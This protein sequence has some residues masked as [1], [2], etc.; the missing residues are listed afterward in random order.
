MS[1]LLS[2]CTWFSISDFHNRT[3]RC[4]NDFRYGALGDWEHTYGT[5]TPSFWNW[6]FLTKSTQPNCSDTT[7]SLPMSNTNLDQ[8]PKRG[9]MPPMTNYMAR[10][11]WQYPIS[12]DGYWISELD[13]EISHH[14]ATAIQLQNLIRLRS[15]TQRNDFQGE[16]HMKHI[17]PIIPTK[18]EKN[19]NPKLS[20]SSWKSIQTTSPI[21]WKLVKEKKNIDPPFEIAGPLSQVILSWRNGTADGNPNGIWSG[22]SPDH[23]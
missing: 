5:P 8:F 6:G 10:M 3:R 1:G 13:R 17:V 19:G 12:S 7:C 20:C 2:S 11:Q 14:Q 4:C 23:E 22:N 15:F 16:V 9:E 21:S 18:S